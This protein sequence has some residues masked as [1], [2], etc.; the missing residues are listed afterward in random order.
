MREAFQLLKVDRLCSVVDGTVDFDEAID[1]S[2]SQT[3]RRYPGEF[4]FANVNRFTLVG[5]TGYDDRNREATQGVARSRSVP[6]G[7][8]DPHASWGAT[9][10]I[11]AK[12]ARA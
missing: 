4:I 2:V 1:N 7:L 9:P 6:M 8:F 11:H 12:S 5:Q 10:W 3:A